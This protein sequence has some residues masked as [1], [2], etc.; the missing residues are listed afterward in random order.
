LPHHR[1]YAETS[2]VDSA[3][4][5]ND[6]VTMLSDAEMIAATN[7]PAHPH[8]TVV[9][10]PDPSVPAGVR[11][12]VA[13]FGGSPHWRVVATTNYLRHLRAI[14][15]ARGWPAPD[16]RV[17][18]QAEDI[19]SDMPSVAWETRTDWNDVRLVPD[20]Y[21]FESFGHEGF[22]PTMPEWWD[23]PARFVWRGS[24]T[25]LLPLHA[26]Q[27][28][29]LPRYRLCRT[30]R[31][32]GHSDIALTNVVQASS[33]DDEQAMRSRLIAEG[34]LV[35]YLP[36]EAMGASARYIFDIDGNANS[37]NFMAKLRLGCCVV[38]VESDWKQWFADRLEPWRHYVPVRSDLADLTDQMAWCLDNPDK[39][40]R[41][42]AEGYRF[43][44]EM[45]FADEMEQATHTVFA[46]A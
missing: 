4:S 30:A 25:G 23:R 40:A 37:W 45:R 17:V 2:L 31:E 16:R 44:V 19:P 20:I 5:V 46:A 10:D 22:Q 6:D 1:Y 14:A 12:I 26:D 11:Y 41:I 24:T 36:M 42:A 13:D 43:A 15:V 3:M 34:L 28:D 27:L 7:G 39:S 18:F 21:Y 32:F 9:I 38:K 35:D 29:A 33:P 8:L